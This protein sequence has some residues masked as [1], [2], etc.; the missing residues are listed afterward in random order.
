MPWIIAGAS[1]LS[2]VI[3][4]NG[5]Q[6]AA[7]TQSNA[8]NNAANIQAQQRAPWVAAGTQAL[9]TLQQ[10][11]APGGQYTQ[12]FTMAD[13]TNAPV[14]QQ[15]LQDAQLAVSNSNA[16]KG[17]LLNS[18]ALKQAQTTAGNIGASF[19]NDAFNQWMQQQNQQLN[20]QQSLAQ[21]GQT[22][23]NAVADSASNAAL[24]VG[25]AQ[26]GAQVDSTNAITGALGNIFNIPGIN[27]T[28]LSSIFG[29][30][31]NAT[32][33]NGLQVPGAAPASNFWNTPFTMG[34][35]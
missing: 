23:V 18:N 11:L 35:P 6:S 30:G 21:V 32:A 27:T 28:P 24:A 17:G 22:N 26:A 31:S 3:S 9:N 19:E 2:G 12:K 1:L 20:A 13:A 14:E 7:N 5:A 33:G 8:A 15:A 16:A 34:G 29:G 25:N 10:G 4:S